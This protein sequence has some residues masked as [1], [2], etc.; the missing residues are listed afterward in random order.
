MSASANDVLAAP[1]DKNHIFEAFPN[2]CNRTFQCS[3]NEFAKEIMKPADSK[4]KYLI[5]N[6]PS[7]TAFSLET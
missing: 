6:Q 1:C 7:F 3:D 4:C 2:A 5:L